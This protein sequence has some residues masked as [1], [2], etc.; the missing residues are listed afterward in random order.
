MRK[1]TIN[2]LTDS[3]MWYFIYLLPLILCVVMSFNSPS[4]FD[5]TAM[6]C[7]GSFGVLASESNVI[8]KAF[9][10]LFG[11]SGVLP[12]FASGD[13]G[14]MLYMAYFCSVML[15][16]LAVDFIVFI[17][18]LAHKYMNVFTQNRED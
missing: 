1:R 11:A 17:P 13:V 4:S 2:H 7:G 9:E 10:A 15:L 14:I 5:L 18:R 12:L 16:H 8:F 3:V 6:L